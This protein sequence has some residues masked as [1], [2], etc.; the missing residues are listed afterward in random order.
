MKCPFCSFNNNEENL[1]CTSCGK[2]LSEIIKEEIQKEIES[3][4]KEISTLDSESKASIPPD[5]KKTPNNTEGSGVILHS[6]KTAEAKRAEYRSI[7]EKVFADG[8]ITPE[9]L[10]DLNEKRKELGLNEA[11]ALEVQKETAKDLGIEIKE[12]GDLCT[13]VLL[14]INTNKDY[15][16]GEMNNLEFK[17][18]NRFGNSLEK[19]CLSSHFEMLGKKEEKSIPK[20]SSRH[21]EVLRL[22][23]KHTD[24]GQELVEIRVQYFDDKGNPTVLKAEIEVGISARD[25][26]RE[27][28]KSINITVTAEKMMGVDLSHMAEIYEE[29]REPKAK[30]RSFYGEAEKEWT[31]LPIFLDEEETNRWRE[32]ILIDKKMAEGERNF[33]GAENFIRDAEKLSAKDKKAAREKYDQAHHHLNEAKSCFFKVRE[34]NQEHAPSLDRIRQIDHIISEIESKAG[35]LKP[36]PVVQKIRLNSSVL[37]LHD[38]GKRIFLYSKE[39]IT[40]GRNKQN[41][42]ILRLVPNTYKKEYEE[43][44]KELLK[45]KVEEIPIEYFED[46]K[47]KTN[48]IHSIRISN[49]HAEIIEKTGSFYLRDVGSTN[50]TFVEGRK[51]KPQEEILLKNDTRVNI[52][53]V[54]DLECKFY[55]ESKKEQKNRDMQDSC[56][57]V[58]GEKSDS[59]FGIDKRGLV[60]AIKFKRLN[61]NPEGEEYLI[62]IREITIGKDRT[63]A[64]DI[65]GEKVSDIHARII[66]RDQQYWIEDLNS[67]HGTWVNGERVGFGAEVSLEK[68]AEIVIG[69]IKMLFEGKP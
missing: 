3:E 55:K 12:M 15:F 64:I 28:R 20:M 9:E 65:D 35:K 26:V 31:G 11:E 45:G 56:F 61:N 39:E 54:L 62:L 67:R 4:L 7:L 47:N 32:Q 63:N 21:Q 34:I 18:T 43:R 29:K 50:G 25:E 33:G 2:K 46:K 57:T 68:E 17:M 24:R 1:F 51:L 40:L 30:K 14:E 37:K 48:F 66:Y 36:E 16:V 42:M 22:P 38:P 5:L 41:D 69:D 49:K 58:L 52:A 10:I 23:F 44:V 13:G 60:N 53:G 8:R 19:V 6:E 27:D 59:C